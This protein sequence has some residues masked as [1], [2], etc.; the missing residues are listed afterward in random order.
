MPYVIKDRVSVIA[1]VLSEAISRLHNGDLVAAVLHYVLMEDK[2]GAFFDMAN[3]R[4]LTALLM[5]TTA[6]YIKRACRMA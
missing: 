2:G 5:S 4:E 3:A 6:L 1:R